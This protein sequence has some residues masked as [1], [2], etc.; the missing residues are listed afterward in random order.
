MTSNK[1]KSLPNRLT[2]AC[3][4]LLL[5]MAFY[6]LGASVVLIIIISTIPPLI[7]YLLIGDYSFDKQI[8]KEYKLS[9]N[10]FDE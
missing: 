3:L 1:Q 9:V 6:I 7:I 8:D 4:N 5:K 10:H 2:Y